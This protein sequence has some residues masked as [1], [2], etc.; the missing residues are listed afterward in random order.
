[1]RTMLLILS[2]L[3]VASLAQAGEKTTPRKPASEKEYTRADK[4]TNFGESVTIVE[5]NFQKNVTIS[6]TDSDGKPLTCHGNFHKSARATKWDAYQVSTESDDCGEVIY[7]TI[8]QKNPAEIK[9]YSAVD[10]DGGLP[11]TAI[12]K[13]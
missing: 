4:S 13:R 10:S 11:F 8:N 9:L 5:F 1:M 2:A 12:Y 7:L 3:F 6:T